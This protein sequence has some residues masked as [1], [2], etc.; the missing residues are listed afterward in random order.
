M[1]K[2]AFGNDGPAVDNWDPITGR[3]KQM[4]GDDVVIK[5]ILPREKRKKQVSYPKT[6]KMRL[7]SVHKKT[8]NS[9]GIQVMEI[10]GK[11]DKTRY[12]AVVKPISP[13]KGPWDSNKMHEDIKELIEEII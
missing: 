3:A 4:D 13:I 12:V 2:I 7:V 8:E 10:M 9:A 1:T 11:R 5:G 6:N